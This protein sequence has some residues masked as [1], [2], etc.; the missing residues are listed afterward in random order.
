V[1]LL[2]EN[3]AKSEPEFTLWLATNHIPRV[4]HQDESFWRRMKIIPCEYKRDG[5]AVDKDLTMKLKE[6]LPGI[7]NWAIEGCI[8]WQ[9]GSLRQ[10]QGVQDDS[11]V[12]PDCVVEV[13]REHPRK[14]GQ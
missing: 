11:I 12:Y 3:F 13:I 8:R 9:E 14:T 2:R 6:E 10:Q 7:L 5:R 1:R 4:K